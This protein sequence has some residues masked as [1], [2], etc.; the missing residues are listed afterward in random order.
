MDKATPRE[1]AAAKRHLIAVS[2]LRRRWTK[3]LEPYSD[4]AIAAMYEGFYFSDDAG[5]NDEKLPNWF[6]MLPQLQEKYGEA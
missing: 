4:L 6:G 2:N 3:E 1:V 5:S